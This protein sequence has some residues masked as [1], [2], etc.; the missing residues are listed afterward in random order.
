MAEDRDDDAGFLTRWSRR[1]RMSETGAAAD[2]PPDP[3]AAEAAAERARAAEAAA[4]EA[5]EEANRRA[6]EAID[7]ATLGYGDDF[8]VFLRRG[9]PEALRRDALRRFFH[10]DPLLANLDG[11]NDYDLDFNDPAHLVYRSSRDAIHGFLGEAEKALRTLSEN[12]ATPGERE[13][14]RDP[15]IEPPAVP[16]AEAAPAIASD[17]AVRA[18]A[19]TPVG[20]PRPVETAPAGDRPVRVSLRRRLEG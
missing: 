3:V 18:E 9:V 8:S 20:P 2:D 7:P 14:D 6:A 15:A 11:L 19:A 17:G 4:V 13:G 16:A 12:G 5:E 1:K 10:S